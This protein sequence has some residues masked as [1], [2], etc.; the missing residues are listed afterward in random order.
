MRCRLLVGLLVA[1]PGLALM[2]GV[3][4]ASPTGGSEHFQITSVNSQPGSV[5]ARGVFNAGGTDYPK[6]GHSDLFVFS[7]GAFMVRHPGGGS[8]FS[9][10]PK[11]CELRITFTGSYKLNGG[12]GRY[13]GISGSGT[14]KGTETGFLPR[15]PNGTCDE[16]ANA[17]PTSTVQRI[18]AG[19]P[20]AFKG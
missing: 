14:Y 1:V 19:G 11:T 13:Q 8:A 10:N 7:D 16:R 15:N 6:G 9:V 17:Q 5:L 2:P 3:A 20:V 12:V 4:S 18:S